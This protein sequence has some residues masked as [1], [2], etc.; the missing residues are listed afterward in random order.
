MSQ[1]EQQHKVDD[2]HDDQLSY[3]EDTPT[4][5]YDD[6]IDYDDFEVVSNKGGGGGG[7]G[8]QVYNSKH[9]RKTLE[10]QSRK[11]EPKK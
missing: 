10:N 6:G 11:S 8:K 1:Q 5:I 3:G 9:V 4:P 7:K 2:S